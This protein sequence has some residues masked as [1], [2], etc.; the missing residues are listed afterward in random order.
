MEL[1]HQFPFRSGCQF[2]NPAGELLGRVGRTII[3][4][5]RDGPHPTTSDFGDDNRL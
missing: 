1:H 5:Q 4:D 2:P 3:E